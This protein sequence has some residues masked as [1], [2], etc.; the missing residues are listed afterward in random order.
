MKPSMQV[1][2]LWGKQAPSHTITAI[3]ITED[4]Q[5][6]VTGSS[7]GQLCLWDL[8]PELKVSSKQMLFGHTAPVTCLAKARDFEKQPYVVSATEN[9]EMGIWSVA[10]GQCVERTRLPFTHTAICFYHSSFRMTGEGWLLCCGQYNDILVIDAKTLV[11]LHVLTSSQSSDWISCMCLVHSPRIQED[12]LIAVSVTGDLKVWDL[13]SSISRIQDKQCVNERESQPLNCTPCHAIRF[14]T[15]TE[16]LLLVVLSSCWK[17]YDYCDFSLLWTESSPRGQRFSGGEILAAHR[18]I[19]WTEEG[20]GYIY[21]LLNSGLSR[22]I[23]SSQG[24]VLKETVYPVL[25]CSTSMG[26][27]KSFSYIMGFMNERKEPFYKILYS[28]EASGR[29]TLWHIPDVPAS[30]MDGSPKEIPIAASCTLQDSFDAHSPMAE[31]IIDHLSGGNGSGHKTTTTTSSSVY[32]PS[33][34]KLVCGCEDGRIFVVLALTAAK[35]RLLEDPSL[36]K[37]PLSHRIL[38]GHSSSVTSLLYLHGCS[39]RFDPSWL[40]SGSQDSCVIWWD[41]FTGELLHHFPLQAGPVTDLLLS[42]ENYRFKGHRIVCCL[43]GD[44]SVALLHIQERRCI[45]HARKHLFPVTRLCWHPGQNL[46]IVACENDSIYVWDID[47]GAL[48]RQ[49]SG[50]VA[51]AILACSED[52]VGPKADFLLPAVEDNALESRKDAEQRSSFYQV[53]SSPWSSSLIH[54]EEPAW[55]GSASPGRR[56]FTMWPVKTKWEKINVHVLLFDLA[57]L[58]E[59]LHS[60]LS[61][62]LKSSNSFHSYE[63]L[64]RAKSAGEKKSL[65]LKRNRTAASLSPLNGTNATMATEEQPFGESQAVLPMEP[66]GGSS[67]GSGTKRP[68]KPKSSK[69][70]RRQPSGRVNMNIVTDAGKLLLSCVLPWGVDGELDELCVRH[71]DVRRLRA[72]VSLGLVSQNSHLSLMLPGW[73]DARP[74]VEG[75]QHKVINLFSSKVLDLSRKYFAVAEEQIGSLKKNVK[76]P[77]ATERASTLMYLLSRI[78]L[79]QQIIRMPLKGNSPQQ[80]ESASKRKPAASFGTSSSYEESAG[81]SSGSPPSAVDNSS[82]ARVISCWRNQSVE[83][84]EVIQAVLLAEVQRGF[85][86]QRKALA[87]GQWEPQACGEFPQTAQAERIKIHPLLGTADTTQ[88]D[89]SILPAQEGGDAAKKRVLEDSDHPDP[90]KP[91][92]WMSKVC[93]CKIC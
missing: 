19:V 41:I 37:D 59:L 49:E 6:L 24:G 89:S 31:D 45:L 36:L 75:Q 80:V 39:A 3:L 60:P 29:I 81:C 72:P 30:T 87:S 25:L 46:L 79:A 9:G 40:L 65:V 1:V 74:L 70:V 26:E 88:C 76:S 5:T 73:C 69:K 68:K 11:V 93:S 2:T 83:V 64:K 22:S 10:R 7:E 91:H 44:R 61:L 35:A 55:H 52:S 54:Q 57:R 85:R 47:T 14:C 56:P 23:H 82:L 78:C 84:T 66:G 12:S 27:K 92:P 33:L 48:E 58:V 34:N 63:A 15:Y 42:S 32:I 18:L 13:S 50:E 43:C 4:Q 90:K 86:N 67:S 17:V 38:H 77:G 20:L 16:R 28:G 21:Q 71:L 62:R 51:Q 8:S 53:G